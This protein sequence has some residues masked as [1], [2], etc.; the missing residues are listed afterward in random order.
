MEESRLIVVPGDALAIAE[1]REGL[2]SSLRQRGF[3]HVVPLLDPRHAAISS[4]DI[5]HILEQRWHQQLAQDGLDCGKFVLRNGRLRVA[6]QADLPVVIGHVFE[7]WTV[8]VLNDRARS[9][10]RLVFKWVTERERLRTNVFEPFSA[11]GVAFPMTHASLHNPAMRQ[12]DVIFVRMN[13]EQGV[14][15]PALVLGSSIPAGLQVKAIR[16]G[17]AEQI[18]E[19]IISGQYRRVVTYLR[20]TDGRHSADAV[21]EELCRRRRLGIIDEASAERVRNAVRRPDALGVEQREVDEYF[22]YLTRWYAQQAEEDDTIFKTAALDAQL[23]LRHSASLV[24]LR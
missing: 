13:A 16:S 14:P 21:E 11:V 10:G 24:R 4:D 18:I 2:V 22:D 3:D 1:S 23:T 5:G 15:E 17:E 20:H 6:I 7:A 8:R 19:P 9:T 12:F